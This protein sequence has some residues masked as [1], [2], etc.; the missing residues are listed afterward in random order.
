MEMRKKPV[1]LNS[2]M[3]RVGTVAN[4]V[5][6]HRLFLQPGQHRLGASDKI[7]QSRHVCHGPEA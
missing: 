1:D 7:S 3:V 5:D 4:A 6:C 2:S